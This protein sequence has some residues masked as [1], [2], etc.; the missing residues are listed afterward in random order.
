MNE[1]RDFT[2]HSVQNKEASGFTKAICPRFCQYPGKWQRQFSETFSELINC[3]RLIINQCYF[4]F[5]ILFKEL[6]I[7]HYLKK[8]NIFKISV[9]VL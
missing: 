3:Q 9:Q 2:G 6:N 8:L 7:F 1:N 4:L 5:S